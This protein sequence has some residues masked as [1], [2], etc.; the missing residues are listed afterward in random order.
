MLL[1]TIILSM[2]LLLP[3]SSEGSNAKPLISDEPLEIIYFFSY[4]CPGCYAVK[5]YVNMWSS[6][7]GIKMRR[8]PVFNEEQWSEGAYLYVTMQLLTSKSTTPSR[9]KLDRLAFSLI[10]HNKTE[11]ATPEGMYSLLRTA[12]FNSSPL[13]FMTAYRE[14]EDILPEFSRILEEV[15]AEGPIRT[16]SLRIS[17]KHGVTWHHLDEKSDNPGM[18]FISE[19]QETIRQH[20]KD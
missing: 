13:E 12:G 1:K 11:V 10:S 9:S 15:G 18:S 2:A 5:D 14:A 3:L 6:T 19:A 7:Q 8:V 4:H 20:N 16:P 17:S